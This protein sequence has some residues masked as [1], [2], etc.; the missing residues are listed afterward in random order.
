M[1]TTIKEY[2]EQ[3]LRL[4]LKK[5]RYMVVPSQK[6][7]YSGKYVPYFLSIYFSCGEEEK[8]GGDVF[9]Y[10]HARYVNPYT[11]EKEHQRHGSTIKEEDEDK[12]R[13]TNNFKQ[14]LAMK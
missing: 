12:E 6:N 11:G 7:P 1:M 4:S 8:T 10:F 5:G 9:K 14:L 2:R 3:S 13:Y